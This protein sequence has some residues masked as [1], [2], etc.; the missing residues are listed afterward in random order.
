[1]RV[2][3]V[4]VCWLQ[5]HPW[6][7]RWRGRGITLLVP[8]RSDSE[9]RTQIWAWLESY[10][11]YELPAAT[12]IMGS[13]DNVPFCK[14]AAVNKAFN[15]A[16]GNIVVILDA[17]CYLPGNVITWC[18]RAIRRA[19][20][21]GDKLWYIPY[22]HFYRLTEEAT[23]GL[24]GTDPAQPFQVGDPPPPWEV[25]VT[26]NSNY[27]H[28]FGALIQVMSRTAFV[29]AGGMDERFIGWGGEDVSFMNA[30]DTLYAPHRTTRNGV[31]HL[32]HPHVGTEHFERKWDGQQEPGG[33]NPLALRYAEARGRSERMHKLTREPGAGS[34]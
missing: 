13:D 3:V 28:W 6:L 14:T 17:D 18:A 24:L 20:R 25:E 15:I 5:A 22:R 2:L 27:G 33:N 32:W 30:V 12:I 26:R 10:W 19:E 11:K 21:H 23:L 9:G 31:L 34:L 4:L 29:A 16:K 1:M 8:F 7:R